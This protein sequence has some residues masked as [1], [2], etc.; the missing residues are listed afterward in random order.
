MDNPKNA[1]NADKRSGA[2]RREFLY[3][4]HIPERR[5]GK[6]RRNRFDKKYEF[7]QDEY[8]LENNK[9]YH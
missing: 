5:S 7:F 9:T 6:E 1:S 2:E 4:I 3:A 8:Y